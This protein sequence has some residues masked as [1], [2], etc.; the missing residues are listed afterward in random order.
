MH[1]YVVFYLRVQS[2]NNYV[3]AYPG[4]G[5]CRLPRGSS[6]ES[7]CLLGRSINA[8]RRTRLP[9][10]DLK[11]SEHNQTIMCISIQ[12][13]VDHEQNATR[14]RRAKSILGLLC[15]GIT[16][17]PY[18]QS[19]DQSCKQHAFVSKRTSKS[20]DWDESCE[21][22]R[23]EATGCGAHLYLVACTRQKR[24]KMVAAVCLCGRSKMQSKNYN[25]G[26]RFEYY[27]LR[28]DQLTIWSM[29][30]WPNGWSLQVGI[31]RFG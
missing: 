25:S 10:R 6:W 8:S 2:T 26:Q 7:T 9:I 3:R 24:A 14:K 27:D 19:H 11:K 29:H 12:E 16:A 20:R 28:V 5:T 31:C 15:F 30:M 22:E 18:S 23:T 21:I 13:Y 1:I 4:R 17:P